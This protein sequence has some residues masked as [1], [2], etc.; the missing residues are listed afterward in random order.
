MLARSLAAYETQCG[1][2]GKNGDVEFCFNNDKHRVVNKN[3][4]SKKPTAPL[5]AY[6]RLFLDGRRA[7]TTK[8]NNPSASENFPLIFLVSCF[9]YT[10]YRWTA[11][12]AAVYNVP[13]KYIRDHLS[14]NLNSSINPIPNSEQNLLI[15]LLYIK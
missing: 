15:A 2:R 1:G 4:A 3:R 10:R 9:S 12:Y 7:E 13:G 8:I 6:H 11:V 14:I 5:A